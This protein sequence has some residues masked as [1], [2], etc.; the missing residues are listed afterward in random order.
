MCHRFVGYVEEEAVH[1]YTGAIEA[2]DK[3]LL[4]TWVNK[5]VPEIAQRYWGLKPTATMRDL[6][7]HVRADEALHRDVNHTLSS[8]P[9]DQP[10]PFLPNQAPKH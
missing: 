3:G 7:E 10:N 1:T 4:P 2:Y 8:L 5:P 6:L 9:F